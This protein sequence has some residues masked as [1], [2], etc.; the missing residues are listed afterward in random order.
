M[1]WW[2]MPPIRIAPSRAALGVLADETLAQAV[3]LP[4]LDRPS[5]QLARP[6]EQQDELAA[7]VA[8]L[9]SLSEP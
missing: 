4:H 1:S 5:K 3:H 6:Q 2:A 8:R 7:I 9:E